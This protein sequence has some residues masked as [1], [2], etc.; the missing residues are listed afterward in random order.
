M[1][2][3]QLFTD[4]DGAYLRWLRAHPNGYV[5]NTTRGLSL[6]YMVLH[7]AR[8]TSIS[9]YRG[10]E[11]GAFTERGYVKACAETVDEL[12]AWVRANGRRVG[13]FTSEQCLMCKP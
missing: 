10:A 2:S 7:R 6:N 1:S 4:N 12:R 8:C 11:P 5:V 13:T 3:T 9:D